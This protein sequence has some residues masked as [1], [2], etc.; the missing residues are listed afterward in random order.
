MGV[1]AIFGIFA[2]TYF[3]FP[4]MFGRMMSEPLGK[5]HFWFTFIGAYCIFFPMHFLGMA[6]H[7]RRY[8]DLSG[9]QYLAPLHP[10][11]LFMSI[12]AFVTAAG[13]LFFL[14]N[15]FVSLKKGAPAPVNPWEATTLEWTISSP[16]PFDNFAGR[17]PVINNG[18]YEYSVPG[19]ASDYVMQTDAPLAHQHA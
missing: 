16:P 7:P 17:V 2:A 6:G 12:A 9:V 18:P 13:Q 11:H 15:F 19:A 5:L 14:W 10:L 4:K 8:P 1:A 3:W